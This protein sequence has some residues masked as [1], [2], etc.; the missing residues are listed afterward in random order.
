MIIERI[1]EGSHHNRVIGVDGEHQHMGH[2]QLSPTPH[3]LK[4][5][6]LPILG[7]KDKTRRMLRIVIHHKILHQPS[8]I[9]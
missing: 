7:D 1:I 8:L 9:Y 6:W 5:R 3:P 4:S 2:I